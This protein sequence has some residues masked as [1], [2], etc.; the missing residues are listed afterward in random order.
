MRLPSFHSQARTGY[1]GAVN[2]CLVN[3]VVI[4]RGRHVAA[5]QERQRQCTSLSSEL[6]V[7]LHEYSQGGFRQAATGDDHG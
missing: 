4:G 1:Y 5:Q 2:R 7:A 3:V 6:A